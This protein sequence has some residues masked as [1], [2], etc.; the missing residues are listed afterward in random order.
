MM[1]LDAEGL[2]DERTCSILN[3]IREREADDSPL[4]KLLSG[5]SASESA[6]CLRCSRIEVDSQTWHTRKRVH[7]AHDGTPECIRT[8]LG[9]LDAG[10][11]D[12]KAAER[13][14]AAQPPGSLR[15][16]ESVLPVRSEVPYAALARDMNTSEEALLVAIHRLR[17]RYRALFRQEIAETVA[18]PAEVESEL[19][20]LTVVVTSADSYLIGGG[21]VQVL[22]RHSVGPCRARL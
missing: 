3:I 16:V 8:P 6:S 9:A 20:F 18:D 14:R 5:Y 13:V 21:L 17:E 22:L 11:S 12:G 10:S 15:A 2:R 19:R 7:P 4:D 1:N